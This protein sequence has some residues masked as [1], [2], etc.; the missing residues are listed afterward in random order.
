[1]PDPVDAMKPWTIKSLATKTQNIII[2]AARRENLTVGQWI[3]RRVSEWERQGSP[4][5]R[6]VSVDLPGLLHAAAAFAAVAKLPQDVRLLISQQ[7]RSIAGKPGRKPRQTDA[8]A[9][10]HIQIMNEPKRL[11]NGLKSPLHTDDSRE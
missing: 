7:A 5:T 1:M 9:I 6:S 8:S 2:A 3:E 11:L 4:E 10:N